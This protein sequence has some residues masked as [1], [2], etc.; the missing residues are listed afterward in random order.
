MAF[1]LGESNRPF[2]GCSS[3]SRSRRL[4][5]AATMGGLA[6]LGTTPASGAIYILLITDG[7]DGRY[8]DGDM[9]DVRIYNRALPASE[10]AELYGL[11]YWYKFDETSGST[12]ADSG[13]YGN[14]ATVNAGAASWI[15]GR[16][17]NALA[18]NGA[19]SLVT[20]QSIYGDHPVLHGRFGRVA[21]LLSRALRRRGLGQVPRAQAVGDQINQVDRGAVRRNC[22]HPPNGKLFHVEHFLRLSG[23]CKLFHV[24]HLPPLLAA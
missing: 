2:V 15:T 7:I 21:N 24:E 23:S 3:G 10:I 4:F 8:F 13:P 6:L 1:C 11:K 14:N 22:S 18:F 16:S 20:S 19:S 17:G 12:A 5:V 9:D